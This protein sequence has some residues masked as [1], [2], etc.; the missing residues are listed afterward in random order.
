VKADDPAGGPLH[1]ACRSV[2]LDPAGARRLRGHS[3]SVYLLR[4]RT[5]VARISP[6]SADVLAAH[7]AVEITSWLGSRGF[8]TVTPLPG[9]EQPVEAD[10]RVVTFWTFV[11]TPPGSDPPG[12]ADLGRLLRRLHEMP[13]PPPVELPPFRPLDGFARKVDTAASLEADDRAWLTDRAHQLVDT[14][15]TLDSPLGQGHIHGDAYPG[16][17]LGPRGDS[18]L[19]DWEE[20]AWGPREVDLANTY[21]GVRF[22][23]SSTELDAFARAYGHD[24]RTWDGLNVLTAI[25]DLHTL[26]SYLTRADAGDAAAAAELHRRVASLRATDRTARWSA[27]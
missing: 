1:S 26:G 4:D 10:G 16:N 9:V 17:L 27:A 19:G 6:R 13:E 7:R 12:T 11:E 15:A 20:T 2:G 22:G 14:Y 18:V 5:A 3:A 23:R 8:P 21:Q 24:L 25:R